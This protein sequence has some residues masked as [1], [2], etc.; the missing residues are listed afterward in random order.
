M[1]LP[2]TR[3]LRRLNRPLRVVLSRLGPAD[4]VEVAKMLTSPQA[5]PLGP[6]SASAAG[7]ATYIFQRA[8]SGGCSG[9]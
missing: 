1:P 9:R 2:A 6:E 7:R 3:S 5:V 4:G 8:S